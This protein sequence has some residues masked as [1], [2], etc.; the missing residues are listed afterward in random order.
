MRIIFYERKPP[1][2]EPTDNI[3][4]P[5]SLAD[6]GVRYGVSSF[7]NL[8]VQGGYSSQSLNGFVRFTNVIVPKDATITN[9]FVRFTAYQDCLGTTCNINIYFEDSSDAVA[10]ISAA[11]Y[12]GLSLTTAIAWNSIPTWNIASQYDTP[13]LTSIVQGLVEKISW[14]SGNA[15]MILLKNNGSSSQ[16]FRT[17]ND[18][19]DFSGTR[20]AE[21]HIS[22]I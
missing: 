13:D 10:P 18:F 5:A 2:P 1:T 4:Y 21:L 7:S 20:K 22:W 9:A 19:A 16:A 3:F 6:D 11:T 15:M 17:A 14:S 12:D 8:Y